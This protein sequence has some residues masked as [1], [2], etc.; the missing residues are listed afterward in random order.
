M[1]E[2]NK[3]NTT[4]KKKITENSMERYKMDQKM[5]MINSII[6]KGQS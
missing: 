3:R 4:Q 5:A 6:V 1:Y 2:K